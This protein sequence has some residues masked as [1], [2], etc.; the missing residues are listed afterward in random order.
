MKIFPLKTKHGISIFLA[1]PYQ[2]NLFSSLNHS[3]KLIILPWACNGKKK[4]RER[5]YQVFVK[6]FSGSKESDYL[7]RNTAPS[8]TF[9]FF[10]PRNKNPQ[11]K[12]KQIY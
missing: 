9:P 8:P 6:I 7:V 4:E 12:T 3:L 11:N 2:K 10:A 5:E 1:T